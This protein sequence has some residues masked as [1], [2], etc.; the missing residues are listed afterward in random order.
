MFHLSMEGRLFAHLSDVE[1]TANS[2]LDR[3]MPG[4]AKA[5]GTTE[6]LKARDQ[7]A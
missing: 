2:W 7:I 3:M 1:D 5:A 4:M 6:E